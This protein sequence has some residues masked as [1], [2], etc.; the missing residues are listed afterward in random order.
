MIGKDESGRLFDDR[1]L[2]EIHLFR[3]DFE[4]HAFSRMLQRD[5]SHERLI[6]FA[7]E[8]LRASRLSQS[9]FTLLE[10]TPTQFMWSFRVPGGLY[11]ASAMRLTQVGTPELLEERWTWESQSAPITGP[12]AAL[13]GWVVAEAHMQTPNWVFKDFPTL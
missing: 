6:E 11:L 5:I 2:E 4:V 10:F 9:S 12:W 3:G 13:D 7:N 1:S 8:Q